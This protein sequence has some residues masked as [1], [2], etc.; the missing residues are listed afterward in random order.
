MSSPTSSPQPTV[1]A[2]PEMDAAYTYIRDE[3]CEQQCDYKLECQCC[4]RH[5][6]HIRLIKKEYDELLRRVKKVEQS[7]QSLQNRNQRLEMEVVHMR[8][9]RNV[10]RIK[11]G[12]RARRLNGLE[13]VMIKTLNMLDGRKK[14]NL[15]RILNSAEERAIREIITGLNDVDYRT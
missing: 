9:Q 1:S 12:L 7:E 14:A 10:L 5:A 4:G 2:F 8:E 3:P 15:K 13:G 6:N 11:C